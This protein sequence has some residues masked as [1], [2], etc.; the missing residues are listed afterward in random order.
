MDIFFFRFLNLYPAKNG[1]KVLKITE[2]WIDA[3]ETNVKLE[4]HRKCGLG[5][6]NGVDTAENDSRKCSEIQNFK[7]R[8]KCRP[9]YRESDSR[10]S[11][12]CRRVPV[13]ISIGYDVLATRTAQICK[14]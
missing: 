11:V 1:A 5:R 8:K 13:D 2:I 14:K 4:K 9:I 10:L 6:K 7:D 12:S 3:K